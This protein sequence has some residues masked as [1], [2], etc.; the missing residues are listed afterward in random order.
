MQQK[1]RN[2]AVSPVVGVMLMLVVTIIIA[3]VVSAYAGGLSKETTKAPQAIIH[4]SYSISE[5]M[6]I[7]HTGGDPV[8][9]PSVRFLVYP[10]ESFGTSGHAVDTVNMTSLT[11]KSGAAWLSAKGSIGVKTFQAGDV[12]IIRPPYSEGPWLQPSAHSN[13][14]FNN[15]AN[16][17]K[18]FMVVMVDAKGKM[19]AKTEVT[20]ES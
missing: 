5:G 17:G 6:I 8:G 4:G 10:A 11:D 3:A 19:I 12:A 14:W 7:E 2:D 15:S 16:L 18:T 1:D 9:T 13:S 20:I